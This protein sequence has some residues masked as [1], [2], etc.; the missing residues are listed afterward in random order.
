LGVRLD[1]Y[2]A[3][4]GWGCL[5]RSEDRDL[6]TRLQNNGAS[7][8]SPCDLRVTTSGRSVGRV[9]EGFA[10][11]LREQVLEHQSLSQ[12]SPIRRSA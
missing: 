3:A 10:H 6:W 8:A 12:S 4:G 5:P 1:A 9:G 2:D 11:F 7:L